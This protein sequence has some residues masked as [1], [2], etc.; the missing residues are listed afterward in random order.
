MSQY[1]AAY[2]VADDRQREKIAKV[3]LQYGWRL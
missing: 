3:L 1:V 2:D